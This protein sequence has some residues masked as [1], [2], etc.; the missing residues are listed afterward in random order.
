VNG[1]RMRKAVPLP[2]D[3]ILLEPLGSA[4]QGVVWRSAV[5]E[6]S[7]GGSGFDTISVRQKRSGLWVS[8]TSD[9]AAE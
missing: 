3:K 4:D 9:S 5:Q 8:I 2:E 6:F 1:S 7:R